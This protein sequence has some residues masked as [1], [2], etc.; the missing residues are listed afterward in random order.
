MDKDIMLICYRPADPEEWQ[1]V[2]E[3]S[4]IAVTQIDK[5]QNAI[6]SMLRHNPTFILLDLDVEDA[7]EFLHEISHSVNFNPPPYILSTATFSGGPD[8][9]TVFDLGADACI[10]KP[11]D[12]QEVVA[13]IRAVLRR[14]QKIA[15]LKIERA[16]PLVYKDL[17]IDPTRRTATM[18]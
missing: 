1:A 10:D 5:L 8:R 3:R 18:H 7:K 4:S 2:L 16:L 9:A 13:L 6:S 11:I 15:R 17:T 14:E 12:P